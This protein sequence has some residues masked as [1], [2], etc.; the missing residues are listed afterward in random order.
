MKKSLAH[1][2]QR[3]RAEL[4]RIVTII[5]DKAPATEMLILYG[6]YARGDYKEQK[7]LAPLRKSGHVSDYDILVVT[8][9]KK[10]AANTTLWNNITKKCDKLK[11]STHVR[12]IAH[13][14][15]FLNIQLAEGQYFFTDILLYDTSRYK[16]ARKRKLKPTEQKRIAQDFYN[17]WFNKAKGFYKHFEYALRDKDYCLAAFNL[18]QAAEASYKAILLVFTGYN[19][20]EHYLLVLGH[21]A[22][23]HERALRNIFPRKTAEQ[24]E[25]FNLLDYAY[26]GARYDPDYKITKKQ[27]EY[28]SKR[29]KLLQRLTKKICKEKIESFT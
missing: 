6:S 20:N 17:Y 21:M 16:L 7:D 29:V 27:L 2:P 24:E 4:A 13:D 18:H 14:I 9:E 5:R 8:T 15:Q 19:P 3:K 28:L 26:I 22:G 10:T 11:L 1:L 23:K 25:L 12:L